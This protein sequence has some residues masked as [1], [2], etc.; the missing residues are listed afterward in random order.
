MDKALH[1]SDEGPQ[2]QLTGIP[3]DGFRF[4]VVAIKPGPDV[5]GTIPAL[6]AYGNWPRAA[7]ITW[8]WKTW[9]TPTAHERLKPEYQALQKLWAAP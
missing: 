4:G 1:P 8:K 2:S 6:D 9:E 5:I 7:F 3:S